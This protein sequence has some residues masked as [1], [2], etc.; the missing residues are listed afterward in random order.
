MSLY[1]A[2]PDQEVSQLQHCL[3]TETVVIVGVGNVALD[4]ARLILAPV[5][6]IRDG[7]KKRNYLQLNSKGPLNALL[8]HL[9]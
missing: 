9:Q 2:S 7:F 3:D 8:D 5:D 4:V 6:S 1:N